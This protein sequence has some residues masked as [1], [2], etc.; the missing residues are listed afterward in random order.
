MWST[1]VGVLFYVQ[2]DRFK[3]ETEIDK[4]KYANLRFFKK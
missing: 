2:F 4:I 3:N 1:R